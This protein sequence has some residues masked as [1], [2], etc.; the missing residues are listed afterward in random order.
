[1]T[2][3]LNKGL[4]LNNMSIFDCSVLQVEEKLN[5]DANTVTTNVTSASQ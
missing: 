3:S 5:H 1:M 2:R 4:V